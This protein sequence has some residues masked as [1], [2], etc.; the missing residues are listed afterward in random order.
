MDMI[1][2]IFICKGY[3]EKYYRLVSYICF[4]LEEFMHQLYILNNQKIIKYVMQRIN[5]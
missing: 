4:K 5:I 3:T 1:L 2:F